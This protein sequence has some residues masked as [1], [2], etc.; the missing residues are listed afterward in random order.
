MLTKVCVV[1][2]NL[3]QVKPYR[4]D[5]AIYCSRKCYGI[6]IRGIIPKSSFKK[7]FQGGKQFQSGYKHPYFGKSSPALGK[8]WKRSKES[9][10]LS[11]KNQRGI[12]RPNISGSN[13]WNWQGGI[14]S[15]QKR[16]RNALEYKLWRKAIFNRDN[17]T[18]QIC[19]ISGVYL[20]ADHIKPFAYYPELRLSIDNGRTLCI[21]CHS[22]T[23]T[24]KGRASRHKPAK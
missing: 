10:E 23:D 24:Y 22:N 17:Y 3:F 12:P 16:H 2:S 1:C 9:I 5:T 19:G 18:C 15:E 11:H 13:H 4:S 6:S 8:R 20:Q 21:N 14:T 7:G